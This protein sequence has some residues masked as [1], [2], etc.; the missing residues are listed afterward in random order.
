MMNSGKTKKR[1]SLRYKLILI[2]G[3]LVFAASAIEA[4]LAGVALDIDLI[5]RESFRFFLLFWALCLFKDPLLAE[6]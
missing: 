3:L 5:C 4:L 1:F 2:F 6:R